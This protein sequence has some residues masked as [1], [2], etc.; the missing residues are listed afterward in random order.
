MADRFPLA[1]IPD[2]VRGIAGRLQGAGHEAWFVGGAIRDVLLELETG[3]APRRSGDFDIATS[4][5]PEEVQ[6]L[7][8]RT[9]PVGIEHGT[10]AVLDEEGRTHEVTTFRRDVKTDGR[11]AEVEFGVSLE[12]DLARRDFTINAVAVHPES[13]DLRDPFGGRTDLAAR[14]VRAVGDAAARMREDRLRVLRA[15]RFATALDFTID[16][17]T[18]E[19]VHGS[20]QELSGLSR[21]RVRD[22]WL[23]T[24]ATGRPSV[25]VGLWRRAGVL[26]EVWPELAALPAD[27][28]AGFDLVEGGDPVLVTAAMLYGAGQGPA[29][30]A[31]AAQRLRF[32]NKD[33]ERVRRTVAALGV[34]LPDA[35][36][37]RAVRRW[38]AANPAAA[39]DVLGIVPKAIREPLAAA[40]RAERASGAPL[41]LADL[42]VTGADLMA[43]GIAAGPGLGATLRRLLE[44]A[45]DD[46][47]CNTR[48]ALLALAREPR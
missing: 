27:A 23:K 45:L 5:R 14:V 32:S 20:A 15:L 28:D 18:W 34:P 12:D 3:R 41:T 2:A 37:G 25:A 16:P 29:G 35:R 31:A 26:G 4:A 10:I 43:A 24:L 33:A 8:R 42:A 38:L 17:G 21:E 13:G 1:R 9:V 22:E 47:A 46:P 30:A 44:A 6:A 48:E 7:F 39:D 36:D 11:H 19:A 40:V